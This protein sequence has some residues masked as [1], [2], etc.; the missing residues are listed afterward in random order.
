M[1]LPGRANTEREVSAELGL[2]IHHADQDYALGTF[3]HYL[4]AVWRTEIS[5]PSAAH[6]GRVLQELRSALPGTALGVLSVMEDTCRVPVATAATDTF[7]DVL[8][9]TGD[10]LK[11]IAVVYGREGFWGAGARSQMTTVLTESKAEV[12]YS[13]FAALEPAAAWLV[14]M[15]ADATPG[16]AVALQRHLVALR[17][18]VG[19]GDGR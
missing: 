1:N 17:A 4:L 14:D 11:G 19:P 9:R 7:A 6:W 18:A 3:E 13:M 12:P 15:L 5:L 10:A 16:C 8:R 2:V